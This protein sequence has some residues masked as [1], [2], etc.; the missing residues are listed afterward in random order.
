MGDLDH[1]EAWIRSYFARKWPEIFLKG[2]LGIF[3]KMN[4]SSIHVFTFYVGL[5]I[6][7]LLE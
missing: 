4:V 5:L 1:V 3:P 2:I 6:Q 7:R